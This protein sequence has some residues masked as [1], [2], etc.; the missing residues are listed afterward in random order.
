ML[1][2]APPG[3]LLMEAE[4]RP[5][6]PDRG[7]TA[8]HPRGDWTLVEL[9]HRGWQHLGDWAPTVRPLYAS[10]GGWT[11]VLGRFRVA[12]GADPRA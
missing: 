5:H 3:G 12:A 6:T 1:A 8:V 11:M 7:R 10:E 2:A 9:E 4:R